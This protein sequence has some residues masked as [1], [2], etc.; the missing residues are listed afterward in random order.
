MVKRFKVET[1]VSIDFQFWAIIPALNINLH[2]NT[3]EF[4]WLCVA[5]Y[6]DFVNIDKNIN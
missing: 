1:E 5:I 4:E 6:W 2:S 3:I